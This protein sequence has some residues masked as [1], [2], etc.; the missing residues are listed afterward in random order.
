[1]SAGAEEISRWEGEG[2]GVVN[3]DS[4]A[5]TDPVLQSAIFNVGEFMSAVDL[6]L[7]SG[8]KPA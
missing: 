2:G 6:A 4:K 1:M 5:T 8:R 3:A 7:S